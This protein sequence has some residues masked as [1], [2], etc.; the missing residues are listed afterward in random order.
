[1]FKISFE[2]VFSNTRP[3]LLNDA[4]EILKDELYDISAEIADK[5]FFIPIES[6]EF[7][8]YKSN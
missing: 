7:N 8:E 6:I 1:M 5:G 4:K 3:D 2:A